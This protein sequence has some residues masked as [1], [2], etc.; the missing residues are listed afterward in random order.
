MHLIFL[1]FAL[2]YTIT[3]FQIYQYQPVLIS[4]NITKRILCAYDVSKTLWL[5]IGLCGEK[6]RNTVVGTDKYCAWCAGVNRILKILW[7]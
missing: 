5:Q 4:L 7:L 2:L 6:K 3:Q 1:L